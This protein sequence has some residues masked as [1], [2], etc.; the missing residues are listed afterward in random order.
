MN[1]SNKIIIISQ[2]ICGLLAVLILTGCSTEIVSSSQRIESELVSK[3]YGET[4]E[5][6]VNRST[7]VSIEMMTNGSSALIVTLNVYGR[8]LRSVKFYSREKD[9]LIE[10]VDTFLE[11]EETA[12]SNGE[13]LKKRITR[14]KNPNDSAM[15][16]SFHSE[17]VGA[18]FLTI[19]YIDPGMIGET[20]FPFLVF[21]RKNAIRFKELLQML[22][23][24]SS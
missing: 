18:H 8:Y 15:Y 1:L 17:S 22:P 5:Q 20:E 7:S 10:A 3:E 21:N 12:S 14:V 19:G 4:K 24:Y 13:I 6:Y 16:L 23:D 9:A 11:W 2:Q